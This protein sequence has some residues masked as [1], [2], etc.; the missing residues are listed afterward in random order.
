[1]ATVPRLELGPADHERP[2][3][4]DDFYSA[5]YQPGYQYE[6]IDGRLYVSPLPNA[7]G[8]IVEW[9]LLLALHYYS[10]QHPEIINFVYNKTR[11]FVPGR[12]AATIPEPDV[13]AYR[14]FP[15]DLD[16]NNINWQ[17]HSPIL[18][19]EVLSDDPDKD[20]VRNLE[21][22]HQV[23]SIKEY[24]VLD[25]RADANCP[26][27]LVH[28]RHGK[29]WRTRQLSFGDTYTTRLLPGFELIIDPRR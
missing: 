29:R 1:M 14:A 10:A 27:M 8:G 2:L 15:R 13:A 17:D 20:L 7:P 5:D 6:I 21:L 26:S 28:L 16:L 24:W 22:Y 23:P 18:V 11:V 4:L 12:P 19:A 3:T 25:P 9:W